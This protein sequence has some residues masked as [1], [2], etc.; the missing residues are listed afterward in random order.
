MTL[1]RRVPHGR[2][3]CVPIPGSF[4]ILSSPQTI[5]IEPC[6]LVHGQGYAVFRPSF[7]PTLCLLD[8]PLNSDSEKVAV[9]E[10]CFRKRIS[11]NS[12]IPKPLERFRVVLIDAQTV[13]K[14][15]CNSIAG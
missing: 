13:H 15:L 5:E 8:I 9:A 1:T 10:V 11:E 7:E 4:D 2:A 6:K 12:S 3:F 14:Q